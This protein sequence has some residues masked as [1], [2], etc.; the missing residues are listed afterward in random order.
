M[1]THFA[2]RR[3]SPP[4][5]WKE[6]FSV[7]IRAAETVAAKRNVSLRTRSRPGLPSLRTGLAACEVQSDRLGLLVVLADGYGCERI[8]RIP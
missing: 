6:D 5:V 1:V 7:S 3:K 4:L 2:R 8:L